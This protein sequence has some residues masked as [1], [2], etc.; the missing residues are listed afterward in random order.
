MAIYPGYNT[1]NNLIAEYD[2]CFLYSSLIKKINKHKTNIKIKKQKA[3]LIH[4]SYLKL[5][6]K[7]QV[8][9]FC[10]KMHF[11][12]KSLQYATGKS[13][14]SSSPL[15]NNQSNQN[16]MFIKLLSSLA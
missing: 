6:I 4:F 15:L 8:S 7:I 11:K 14:D 10:I 5:S 16:C 2:D 9:G 3:K 13:F 12:S 1:P